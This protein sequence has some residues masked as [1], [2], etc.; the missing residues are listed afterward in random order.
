M[1]RF[2]ETRVIPYADT[3][4]FGYYRGTPTGLYNAMDNHLPDSVA[5]R[6]NM[7]INKKWINYQM[8]EG[9]D[10][11]DIGMPDGWTGG[12]GPYYGMELDQVSGYG[13]YSSGHPGGRGPAVIA[14]IPVRAS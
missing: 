4:G 9:K 3:H 8:M 10:L 2:M 7:W 11:V 13:Q 14:A 12:T 5:E 6:A 1:G